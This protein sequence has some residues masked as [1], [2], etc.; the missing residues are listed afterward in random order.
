ML[1]TPLAGEDGEALPQ[2]QLSIVLT[3]TMKMT[4]DVMCL[5]H[6]P[7]KALADGA[8]ISKG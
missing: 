6:S 1:L 5:K 7:G 3:R 8:L 2:K 4:D